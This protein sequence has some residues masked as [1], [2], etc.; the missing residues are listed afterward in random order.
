MMQITT[1]NT[2]ISYLSV[3]TDMNTCGHAKSK[4]YSQIDKQLNTEGWCLLSSDV[5][6]FSHI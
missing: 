1:T 5:A 3:P 4:L 6:R 2:Q